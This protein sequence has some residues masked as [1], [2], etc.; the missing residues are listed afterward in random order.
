MMS[1]LMP[2]RKSRDGAGASEGRKS[3]G[4]IIR[5]FYPKFP[6]MTLSRETPNSDTTQSPYCSRYLSILF[7]SF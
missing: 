7:L 3:R 2:I 1:E 5:Q 4:G 6:P